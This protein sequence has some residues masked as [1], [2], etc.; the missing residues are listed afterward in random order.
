M[1]LEVPFRIFSEV[2]ALTSFRMLVRAVVAIGL[3]VI[4]CACAVTKQG[5]S[6]QIGLDPDEL[7]SPTLQ[8]FRIGKFKG[9]LR[10]NQNNEYQ[11]KL[12]DR[13]NVIKLGQLQSAHVENTYHFSNQDLIV[14]NTPTASC[15]YVYQI[16]GVNGYDVVMWEINNT[17]SECNIPLEFTADAESWRAQQQYNPSGRSNWTW[18]NGQMLIGRDA[19]IG[20]NLVGSNPGNLS[21]S[22]GTH[23]SNSPIFIGHFESGDAS[24]EGTVHNDNPGHHARITNHRHTSV[25]EPES[26]VSNPKALGNTPKPIDPGSYNKQSD[27]GQI[28]MIPVKIKLDSK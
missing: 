17:H 11:I 12:Y 14:V 13:M 10:K 22:S 15:R 25:A 26:S 28:E 5:T 2:L 9:V 23:S 7:T 21:A 18:N 3:S 4:L 8:E 24:N 19:S 1:G 6:Y 20:S 27:G 16:Y